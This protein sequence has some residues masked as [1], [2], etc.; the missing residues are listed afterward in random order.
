MKS[1][2]GTTLNTYGASSL[3]FTVSAI[4]ATY[5]S[6]TYSGDLRLNTFKSNVYTGNLFTG[7]K[8]LIQIEGSPRVVFDSET[9]TNNGDMSTEA[10]TKYG[11]NIISP[12]ASEMTIAGAI[13]SP[14]SYLSTKLG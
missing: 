7:G 3:S 1:L 13:A 14:G 2:S 9:F 12:S 6:I 5:N 8:S 10:I 4:S 11:T